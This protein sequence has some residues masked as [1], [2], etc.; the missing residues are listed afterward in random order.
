MF[1]SYDGTMGSGSWVWMAVVMVPLWVGVAALVWWLFRR[2]GPAGQSQA[3][4]PAHH[5]A[6][7]VLGERFARGEIDEAEF[8]ARRTALRR[9]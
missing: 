6:E 3:R 1:G 4:E 7:Q 5:E 8:M 2:P 9:Q